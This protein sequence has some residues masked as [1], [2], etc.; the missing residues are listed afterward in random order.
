MS[1]ET[2]PDCGRVY[3]EDRYHCR[4]SLND[5]G[6]TDCLRHAAARQRTG[7]EQTSLLLMLEKS[8]TSTLEG[9]LS[10][11]TA[12]A[13]ELEK[14][15]DEARD[16]VRRITAESRALTCVYCGH[17][18][19]PGSPEH[20]AEVLTEHIKTCEKHPMRAMGERVAR[21]ERV[22]KAARDVLHWS[23]ARTG[24]QRHSVETLGAA[25]AEF[26]GGLLTPETKG[27]TDG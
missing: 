11:A 24:M 3:G 12:R 26:E 10:A 23:F 1:E 15:R 14:E 19:P 9:K 2:C 21:A 7:N 8:Y 16:W 6:L 22:A 20:G 27:K 13:S 25:L 18:Y 17:A 5:V 4:S